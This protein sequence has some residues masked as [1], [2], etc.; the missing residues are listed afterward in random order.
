MRKNLAVIVA[1]L[2][3]AMFCSNG[4]AQQ[5]PKSGSINFHTGWKLAGEAITPADKHMVGHGS[6]AGAG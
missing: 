4:S 1:G 6:V 3:F 2:C 5:L